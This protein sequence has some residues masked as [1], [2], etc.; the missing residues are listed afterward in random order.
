[1]RKINELIIHASATRP[2]W[3]GKSPTKRK[4]AEIRRWHV[5]DNGWSDIGYHWIIDRDG[6]IVKGRPMERTGAHT[7]GKNKDTVGI[8]LIGGHG[9][10]ASDAF[11]DNFTFDQDCS[12]TALVQGLVVDY[13]PLK[14]SGHNQYADKACPC[15]EVRD[16]TDQFKA[17]TD[18]KPETTKAVIRPSPYCRYIHKTG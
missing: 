9:G 4:V 1:M 10:A 6:T 3:M 5:E 12:L 15:F 18:P 7:R 14:V 16:W 11:L 17:A 8:C 13:G 2:N